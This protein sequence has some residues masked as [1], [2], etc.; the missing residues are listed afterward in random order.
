MIKMQV[1]EVPI[2]SCRPG[3]FI[4]TYRGNFYIKNIYLA[5][6]DVYPSIIE[7]YGTCVTV[8]YTDDITKCNISYSK[9]EVRGKLDWSA[10]AP[11]ICP[12][13]HMVIRYIRVIN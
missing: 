13:G 1:E 8:E 2:S 12:I 7:T 9:P 11:K 4:K 6:E 5:E 10:H 3:D